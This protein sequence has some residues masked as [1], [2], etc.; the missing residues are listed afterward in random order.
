MNF[1][2]MTMYQMMLYFLSI[3]L[4]AS[5]VLSFI[6]VSPYSALD[7]F[8]QT[9]SLVVICWII[10]FLLGR[11]FKIAVRQESAII[12]ALILSLIMGPLSLPKDWLIV[13]VISIAAI[14]SKY[15]IVKNAQH[16]LNPAAFGAVVAAILFSYPTSW[17]FSNTIIA[18]FVVIGG[19]ILI[20]RLKYFHLIISFYI[21]Y[22]VLLLLQIIFIYERNFSMELLLTKNY[23]L[24]PALMF[25]I[26]IML[27]EPITA[28]RTKVYRIFFGGVVGGILFF[29][30]HL[31][32]SIQFSLELS[33]LCGN[34]FAGIIKY[35]LRKQ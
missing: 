18:Y 9:A 6:G 10:N 4:L 15:L 32:P 16:I 5:L 3:T 1:S 8:L 33:L 27:I 35:R 30:Q 24:S 7:I 26:F 31:A 17:W 28:P 23:L 22:G 14:A 21:T 12:T 13:L 25:F 29:L 34:V 20:H 11:L 2:K 19:I